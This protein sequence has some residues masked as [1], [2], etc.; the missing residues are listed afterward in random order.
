MKPARRYLSMAM[1]AVS[2]LLLG[3]VVAVAA[4]S[5]PGSTADDPLFEMDSVLEF[6]ATRILAWLIIAMTVLGAVLFA[7]GVKQ[8]K[9]KEGKR[10]RSILGLVLGVAAFFLILRYLQPL[11]QS[12]FDTAEVSEATDVVA[13]TTPEQS[14]RSSS[15][16]FSLLVAAIIAAALTRV[17]L[18]A[19][20]GDVSFDPPDEDVALEPARLQS[21][22]STPSAL[23][24]G[25][26]AR[27]RVLAAYAGFELAAAATGLPRKSTETAN[28]HARR[29]GR[30]LGL[31]PG[32]IG[33]LMSPYSRSRFGFRTVTHDEAELA[34]TTSDQLRRKMSK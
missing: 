13:Q 28:R 18:S 6:D 20:E 8:S 22:G 17:G 33:R 23:A 10:K 26:D 32:E 29:V 19:R 12:L 11:S 4:R 24:L 7:L 25:T 15:W 27:S 31:D 16:L 3:F 5:R 21:V 1:A 14:G 34:E 2:L 9:P 30:E